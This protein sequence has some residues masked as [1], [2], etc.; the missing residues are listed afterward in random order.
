MAHIA[1]AIQQKKVVVDFQ[2]RKSWPRFTPDDRLKVYRKCGAPCFAKTIRA[3]AG[4]ILDNPK[5]TLQFPVC[6]VPPPK[7]RVCKVS[8]AGL[9][10]A[11]RR[12]ILTKKYPEIKKQTAKLIAKLGTT[13][14]AR[15]EIKI[16]RVV[17]DETPLPN[18]KHLLTIVY[19]DKVKKQVP[20]TKGHILRK[21]GKYLSQAAH[22]RLSA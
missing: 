14:K 19:T 17:V 9:L 21:Y 13:D 10:A 1:E 4:Q 7:T 5:D 8:A 16:Q 6:R 11:Q 18:G 20:Y 15:K 3:T 22:R 2:D 12:A